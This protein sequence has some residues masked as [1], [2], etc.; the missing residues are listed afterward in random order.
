MCTD[1]QGAQLHDDFMRDLH[2]L[3]IVLACQQYA[4]HAC[5]KK[6][7]KLQFKLNVRSED[8]RC[9]ATM[10]GKG[11][12]LQVAMQDFD[13]GCATLMLSGLCISCLIVYT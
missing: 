5:L 12:P 4:V 2:T 13:L 7:R 6:D 8:T 11:I 1:H 3:C 9:S 10:I